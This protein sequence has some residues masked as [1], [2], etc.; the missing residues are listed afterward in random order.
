M[1]VGFV[2]GCGGPE[3]A[4][5]PTS[6]GDDA[7]IMQTIV[8]RGVDGRTT[9]TTKQVTRAQQR[10]EAA[11]REARLRGPQV[12]PSANPRGLQVAPSSILRSPQAAP[13]S[14][15]RSPQA[16]PPSNDEAVGTI[17]EPLI[18]SVSCTEGDAM[19]IYD[20]P[21]FSGN[22][23]CLQGAWADSVSLTLF[24]YAY[25]WDYSGHLNCIDSWAG[26]VQS[27]W[28]GDKPGGFSGESASHPWCNEYFDT[29]EASIN[30]DACVQRADTLY[31]G[32]IQ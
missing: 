14:I 16:A 5:R 20:R 25:G 19:W 24:C 10:T 29:W 23:L 27:F 18:A 1:L 15:L 30:A 11:A 32:I 3:S 13:S 21:G 2:A 17:S 12:A 26:K 8:R 7:L 9:T 28:A 6:R 4:S 22:E 31:F